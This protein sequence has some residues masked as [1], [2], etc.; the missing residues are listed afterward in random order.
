MEA[1]IKTVKRREREAKDME[2]YQEFL[3]LSSNPES[4]QSEI[5]NSLAKKFGYTAYRNIYPVLRRVEKRVK[6]LKPELV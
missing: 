6:N 4:M 1:P 5:K 3:L 2:I